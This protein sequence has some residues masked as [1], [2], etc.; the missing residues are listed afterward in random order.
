[1]INDSVLLVLSEWVEK[2][3]APNAVDFVGFGIFKWLFTA[4]GNKIHS[5][6][7]HLHF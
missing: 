5:G 6:L 3:E 2:G 1:M 4:I 7:V